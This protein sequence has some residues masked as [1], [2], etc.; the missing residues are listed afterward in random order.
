MKDALIQCALSTL[1]VPVFY[2][3]ITNYPIATSV[4]LASTLLEF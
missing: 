2:V 1:S 4:Y 3:V